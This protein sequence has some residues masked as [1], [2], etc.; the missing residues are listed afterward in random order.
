M[1]EEYFQILDQRGKIEGVRVDRV[2]LMI[3]IDELF[4]VHDKGVITWK[5]GGRE[6]VGFS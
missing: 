2:G 1:T 4:H 3:L 6:A 5:M